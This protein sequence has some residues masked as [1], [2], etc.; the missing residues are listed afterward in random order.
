MSVRKADASLCCLNGPDRRLDMTM[1]LSPTPT[2]PPAGRGQR[3]TK[4]NSDNNQ[5]EKLNMDIIGSYLTSNSI[6]KGSA[7]FLTD[8]ISFLCDFE[9][10]C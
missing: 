7:K 8:N 10:I 6:N 4:K 3:A 1:K 5:G 9:S 2:A